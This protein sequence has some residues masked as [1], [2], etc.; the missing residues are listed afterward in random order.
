M[1]A[2]TA[3]R[4]AG[5]SSHPDTSVAELAEVI[6]QDSSMTAKVLRV[7]NSVYYNPAGQP[8]STVSRAIVILGFDV[9]RTIS[10]S[11]AMVDT[12][13]RGT[14]HR[15][16]VAEMARA[17]HAA[18]Q[19]KA[20]VAERGDGNVEEMFIAAL[21]YRLGPMAFW[22][23]PY[24]LAEAM[25]EALGR[26]EESPERVEERLLGFTLKRLT[27]GL[28]REWHL[29]ELLTDALAGRSGGSPHLR[30]LSLAYDLAVSVERGWRRPEVEQII[31]GI[32][33][34]LGL[35]VERARTLVHDNTRLAART[36]AEYGA[37]NASRLIPL[38]P[39]QEESTGESGAEE[40]GSGAAAPNL[41][42]QLDI[43]RELSAMLSEGV[44]INAALGMVLEG[45]YRGVGMDRAL[46]ALISADG[47]RL[48]AK[49]VLGDDRETL[50]RCFDFELGMPSRDLLT[51]ILREG[52][53][54][55]FEREPAAVQA[56]FAPRLVECL[57]S[58]D[59]FAMPVAVGGRPRGLF[60]A[61]RHLS[62]AALDETAFAG[63]RHFCEQAVIAL[64]MLGTR[65]RRR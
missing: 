54:I 41:A 13:L 60:Y 20:F 27:A 65:A 64:D 38:P 6:L 30:A 42:L 26:G 19:A 25:D 4:I 35:G 51:H 28:N 10:L 63:F 18:V 49:Y 47:I 58:G 34:F 33:E 7:A 8:I 29:S 44:D 59:F 62:G 37:V 55:W 40:E 48:S 23:F 2:H 53:S 56:L 21:L 15:R 1:L 45:I 16:L 46:L 32:G 5:I 9:V 14:Q 52:R 57:G 43:L 31:S 17:F 61:D 24:G 12:M 36:A 50:R 39:L 11:V 22:C 3:R